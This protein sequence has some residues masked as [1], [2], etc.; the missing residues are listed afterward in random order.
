MIDA[1]GSRQTHRA[2]GMRQNM[3][4]QRPRPEADPSR[5]RNTA[6]P[7][8]PCRSKLSLTTSTWHFGGW[9]HIHRPFLDT[10]R[11]TQQII[12]I[13]I[14]IYTTLAHVQWASVVYSLVCR[15]GLSTATLNWLVSQTWR[16][17]VRYPGAMYPGAGYPG[18]GYPAVRTLTTR[19]TPRL[20]APHGAASS[21]TSPW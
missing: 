4:A 12:Y 13:Y 16:D 2:A 6:L 9:S 10:N 7:E 18:A 5:G 17:H 1:P 21:P 15:R 14:Y 8:L 20:H 3:Q 11:H 19:F